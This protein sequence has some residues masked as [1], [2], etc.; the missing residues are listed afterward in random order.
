[1]N[2]D[3]KT[4]RHVAALA[5]IDLE[6]VDVDRLTRQMSDILAYVEQLGEPDVEGIPATAH[7]RPQPLPLREDTPQPGLTPDEALRDAPKRQ[8]DFVLVPRTVEGGGA[9]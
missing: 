9:T 4:I 8:G 6:G 2:V 5:R 7:A 1:M 3:E